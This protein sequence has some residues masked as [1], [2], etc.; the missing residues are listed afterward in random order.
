[1]AYGGARGG[2]KSWAVRKK[3][4]GLAL[5]Y[6][7]ISILI[8]RRTFPELRENHIL[9]MIADLMGIAR[10]RDM[11]KSF[12]F[13][14]GSR[15]VFG[16]CDSEADVLQYQGQEYDV[17]FMDEA[18]QFTEFQFTT[19][20]ACLR[21]A[22]DFPKRFY[23]TC[24]PG[25]VG[26]TWVKRLFI[27][28]QYKA[29]E[30][31][32]D[33]LFIAANVYDNHAL[34]EHDPD[35]VRMLENLPE[36]QRKAWLLGQ[37]DIFE[38]QYFAE[39]DRNVHVC[40]PHGIPAHWRRYVTLDYG[41]DML[42]ALWVAVDEQGRA[43]VYKEL[44]EGRDNGKGAN[45]QGHIIS[46]AARRMLEVNGDDD[47]YT[48]LAPPDLWNRRQDTGKSAAEIFF[49]NGVALT[50]TGN[51]RVAGWLAVREFLALRPDEQGGTSPGLRIFDTCANLIRTLPALRHD[52]KKPEDV[53][54]EP[55]EL[56]HA[57][58]ALR[59]FCTYW[60]TASQA[61]KKQTHDIM[62]DDFSIKKPTAGPLGQGGKYHVI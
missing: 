45:K 23:L 36:E 37:W 5:S 25:G 15:I 56:T 39:F 19:L 48:W 13:P 57:P 8:L 35:Y 2:G 38:G 62:R 4:A 27:D 3:S 53:A 60:S 51:D 34:M 49:E 12:T 24:N 61:P 52:E 58:D 33:Y 7:G 26:H 9:P 30:R 40:R 50:K 11:D 54:N 59:G 16:Y 6:N 44:Y 28:K 10:Y 32:E 17:I 22:N 1:M 18:T 47:I 46:E 41:M 21:G 55:H 43:V 14:N 29:S 31:P 42:A 20:T